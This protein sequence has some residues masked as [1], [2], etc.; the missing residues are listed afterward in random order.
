[1]TSIKQGPF[2]SGQFVF[3]VF[4]VLLFLVLIGFYIAAH[5][6]FKLPYPFTRT[7]LPLVAPVAVSFCLLCL[8]DWRLTQA[9]WARRSIGNI[10]ACLLAFEFISSLHFSY[11]AEWKSHADIAKAVKIA[12]EYA[13]NN[14]LREVATDPGAIAAAKFYRDYYGYD[15]DL[16]EPPS[17]H[18]GYEIY[19]ISPNDQI[20]QAY[21]LSNKG[22]LVVLFRS[23]VSNLMVAAKR[24]TEGTPCG[25]GLKGAVA[26]GVKLGRPKIDSAIE[27]KVRKELAK[28]GYV[29][30]GQVPRHQDS[31]G[32]QRSLVERK[33]CHSMLPCRHCP[34]TQ[35]RSCKYMKI[36]L[37]A[38]G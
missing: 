35:F 16:K 2:R 17:L 32:S 7:A 24:K 3:L 8:G 22:S 37:I 29:E 18:E 15:F 34:Q 36:H 28:G 23:P 4:A 27:R 31:H 25:A 33:N 5:A 11:I 13:K 21:Y 12:G 26:Q 30:V 14:G 19:L 38:Q 10:G 9:N 6:S 1:L 20:S